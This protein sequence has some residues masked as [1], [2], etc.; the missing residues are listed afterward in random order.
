MGRVGVE[1]K[2]EFC[3]SVFTFNKPYSKTFIRSTEI[4]AY[5]IV[6]YLKTI[7]SSTGYQSVL[8][9]AEKPDGANSDHG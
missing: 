3:K 6:T 9:A 5:L 2:E 7:F 8:H 4:N 1:K